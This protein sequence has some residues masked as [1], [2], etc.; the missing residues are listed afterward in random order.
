MSNN[1]QSMKL[2]TE[3]ALKDFLTNKQSFITLDD[4][5]NLESIELPSE[6]EIEKYAKATHY[7]YHFYHFFINGA[8]WMR[9]KIQGGNNEQNGYI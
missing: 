5:Y 2:Y 9:D 7:Y 8:K 3:K 4:F 1:K 6:E